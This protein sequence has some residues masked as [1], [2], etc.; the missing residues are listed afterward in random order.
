MRVFKA[1]PFGLRNAPQRLERGRI[2]GETN[3]TGTCKLRWTLQSQIR[4]RLFVGWPAIADD[5]PEKRTPKHPARTTLTTI[6]SKT[7]EKRKLY[8]A[9]RGTCAVHSVCC[10]GVSL[11]LYFRDTES[12][13]TAALLSAGAEVFHDSSPSGKLKQKYILLRSSIVNH[14]ADISA[15]KF[16]VCRPNVR[17]QRKGRVLLKKKTKNEMFTETDS[18]ISFIRAT[19]NVAR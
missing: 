8:N 2:P 12:V 10:L 16:K 1:P 11:N 6:R 7:H 9:R 14:Y 13:M 18:M 17:R 15:I 19:P 4:A 5:A 3:H